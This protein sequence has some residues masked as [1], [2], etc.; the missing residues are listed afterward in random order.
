[1]TKC[2]AEHTS[3]LQGGWP[4]RAREAE[5][6]RVGMDNVKTDGLEFG[7][8]DVVWYSILCMAEQAELEGG[9]GR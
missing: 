5:L 2:G 3:L 6:S 8:G 4:G 9:A 1:M 7:N